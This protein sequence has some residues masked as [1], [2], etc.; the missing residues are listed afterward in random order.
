MKKRKT[1]KQLEQKESWEKQRGEYNGPLFNLERK[2]LTNPEKRW[3]EDWKVP[4]QACKS[5]MVQRQL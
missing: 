2:S 5:V 3:N 4:A 1:Q